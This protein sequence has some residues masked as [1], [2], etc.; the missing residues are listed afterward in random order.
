MKMAA[1]L[2][3]GDMVAIQKFPIKFER[4][5]RNVIEKMQEVGPDFLTDTL[6]KLGK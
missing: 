3:T 4:T 2:D 5:T 1:S 6:R